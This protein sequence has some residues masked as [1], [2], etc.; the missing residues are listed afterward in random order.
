MKWRSRLVPVLVLA[1]TALFLFD[2]GVRRE[3]KAVRFS[4]VEGTAAGYRSF[5]D[6]AGRGNRTTTTVVFA[7]TLAGY[8]PNVTFRLERP[9]P[10]GVPEGAAVRLEVPADTADT[11]ARASR[12]PGA[13]YLVKVLGASIDGRPVYSAEGEAERAGGASA[14]YKVAGAVCALLA[15]AWAGLLVRRARRRA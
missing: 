5:V 11:V 3:P 13:D 4:V 8:P 1:G 2:Q 9:P 10:A 12:F 15:A 6:G 7:L 14:G